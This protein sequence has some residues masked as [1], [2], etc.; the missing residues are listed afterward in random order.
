VFNWFRKKDIALRQPPLTVDM[1]SH[2][3][4]QLDDGVK[5]LEEAESIILHFHKLGYRKLITTPHVMPD[6]YRNTPATIHGQLKILRAH[7]AS[8]NIPVEIEAAAEYYFDETLISMI[9]N[10]Q[11][12]LTIGKNHILFE[13][14]FITEPFNLK[15][16]IFLATTKGY[17][18]ILAHPERYL[19]MH[20][21]LAKAQDLLDR[22]V[23]FQLNISSITGYY[24][25]PVRQMALKF[26]DRGWVHWLGS[27]CHHAGHMKLLEKT[28]NTKYFRKALSLPLLNNTL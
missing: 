14:N 25:K 17:K 7:L 4:P 27:D 18:L 23:L 24:S 28:M 13:T 22:G 3:L 19:Y 1:H 5:D 8:K 26:I 12:L 2:L 15:E 9:E 6:V 10:D 16:F 20:G 11:P 21:N